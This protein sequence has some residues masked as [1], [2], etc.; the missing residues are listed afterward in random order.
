[1][2]GRRSE[3]HQF[4]AH[5]GAPR[6]SPCMGLAPAL[7]PQPH[8]Q[9][10]VISAEEQP[11]WL[12]K[13]WKVLHQ[14]IAH[15]GCGSSVL[16]IPRP[17]ACSASSSPGPRPRSSAGPW[18]RPGR[19]AAWSPCTDCTGP[20]W[21]H[22]SHCVTPE[23]HCSHQ[24]H[25]DLPQVPHAPRALQAHRSVQTGPQRPDRHLHNYTCAI[26]TACPQGPG[27]THNVTAGSSKAQS[28]EKQAR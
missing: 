22:C 5:C 14:L 15:W 7:P 1:M 4:G 3:L 27:W 2:A 26:C 8:F 10:R 17:Q 12:A 19:A 13:C 21:R 9:N 11:I 18:Q 28:V 25:R 23:V 20:G 6:T 24:Q 16:A